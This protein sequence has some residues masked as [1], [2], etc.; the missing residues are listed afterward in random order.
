MGAELFSPETEEALVGAVLIAP[1]IFISLDI[2]PDQFYVHRLRYI[3]EAIASLHKQNLAVDILTV[4]EELDRSGRLA[5]VGGPAYL[6]SLVNATPTSLHAADYASRIRDLARRRAW[7]ELAS[8]IARAAMDQEVVLEVEAAAV[9]DALLAAVTPSGA[10]VHIREYAKRLRSETLERVSDPRDHWG[11]PTGFADFDRITGGLQPGE[12]LYISGEP[13]V[14]KSIFAMQAA[15]QMAERGRPG[16]I[17]SLEM[18]GAQVVRRRGSSLAKAPTRAVKSGKL[19]SH[20]LDQFMAAL[21]RMEQLPVYMSDSV[22]WTTTGLRADLA[23]LRVRAGIEWFVLDYAYLL[24]DGQGM[25]EN[26]RTG[27]ISSQIKSICRDLSLAGIVIHSLNKSGMT[28]IPGGAHLRG[29]G[30]QYYDTDLLMF[31]MPSDRPGTVRCIFGKGRELENP[32]D[33]FDLAKLPGFPA[34]GNIQYPEEQRPPG[35]NE[36]ALETEP[37]PF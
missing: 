1:E 34:L 25:S 13:G 22:N 10:A 29:S 33:F 18:P 21:D 28:G 31:L 6:I 20:Q 3:W 36:R 32:R 19:N 11:I 35:R 12:T 5:E 16:A 24:Q 4:T 26:D 9:V 27:Y 17:Y 30:Q 37:M 2:R 7:R 23:R 8:R 14:G 15:F